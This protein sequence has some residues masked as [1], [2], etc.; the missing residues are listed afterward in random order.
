MVRL[1]AIL[2]LLVAVSE[3]LAVA[4]TVP[5]GFIFEVK[6]G[7]KLSLLYDALNAKEAVVRI[8]YD[9]KLFK[10]AS[11]RFC[12]ITDTRTSTPLCNVTRAEEQA[13]EIAAMPFIETYWPLEIFSQPEANFQ[14]V[15]ALGSNMTF[16]SN[17][18]LG[19]NM[20]LGTNITLESNST[21]SSRSTLFSRWWGYTP[22]CRDKPY[23]PHVMTQVDKL[24]AKGITGKGV[25][26]AVV[27]TGIDYKHPAL[28]GCFGKKNGKDCLVSFGADFVGDEFTGGNDP[29]PDQ[30]PMDCQVAGIIAAQKNN[31]GFTGAA[32]DVSLGAYKVFGCKGSTSND[33]MMKAFNQAYEDGANVISGSL[34]GP[35]SWESD[36]R[37]VVL[38]RITKAGVPCVISVGNSGNEGQFHAGAPSTGMGVIS[39]A[40]FMST[41]TPMVNII[42]TSTANRRCCGQNFELS[43]WEPAVWGVSKP[44]YAVSLDSKVLPKDACKP[45]PENT[46]DLSKYIVLVRRGRC[47]YGEKA[48]NIAAKGAKHM[49]I[50]N[51]KEKTVPFSL[52]NDAHYLDGVGMV[53]H[54][55]GKK[56]MKNMKNGMKFEIAVPSPWEKPGAKMIDKVNRWNG[57]AVDPSSSWG[58]T[59]DM[60]FKPQLGAP[61]GNIL[62]TYPMKKGGYAIFSGTSMACPM[63]SA[64][65]A[66]VYE[67]RGIKALEPNF[68]IDLLSATAKPQIFNNGTVWYNKLAPPAQQGGGLVQAWDAAYATT[69]LY[70]SSLSFNDSDHF[71]E[72][73]DFSIINKGKTPVRYT[74]GNVPAM[75]T[76]TF[77]EDMKT[78]M[79]FVNEPVPLRAVLSF[80]HKGENVKS[81]T[82]DPGHRY[83]VSV[84]PNLH[85]DHQINQKRLPLW[86]GYITVNGSDSSSFSLPYQGLAGSLHDAPVLAPGN[87]L[88]IF[89]PDGKQYDAPAANSTVTLPAQGDFQNSPIDFR[90]WVK[91]SLGTANLTAEVVPLGENHPKELIKEVM[92]VKTIGKPPGFPQTYMLRGINT[93]WWDGQL[94]SGSYAPAGYYEV[95]IFALRVFGDPNK[96]EDWNIVKTQPFH[97][98]YME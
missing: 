31:L 75:S 43:T 28:G 84:K 91:L 54:S 37:A 22:C 4:R 89:S 88:V 71:T 58:P 52:G 19:T 5:A 92:G 35:S 42:A 47:T 13:K 73:M 6:N 20:S 34:G 21:I 17:R 66:L 74:L 80:Q 30:D 29:I 23:P 44:L 2:P 97:L 53:P 90:I 15:P 87:A 56:W 11:A 69:F 8:P 12:D 1:L 85:A 45:L 81:F 48:K 3:A 79:P 32:P 18:T 86:G 64:I 94:Q 14:A 50:Y 25:K 9:Y 93:W 7:H 59:F 51:D 65:I 10:G 49:I 33:A 77:A 46:R 96:V 61:G 76:Y 67:V 62:S 95:A 82:I 55:V 36:P 41:V 78:P 68:I 26:I 63:L 72:S 40:N 83:I 24:R 70:P 57:G 16:K 38:D 27:D 60:K 39:V 98:K